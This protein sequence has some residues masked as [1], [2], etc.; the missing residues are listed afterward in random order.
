[1]KATTQISTTPSQKTACKIKKKERSL[2]VFT[3][4]SEVFSEKFAF[5]VEFSAF[6]VAASHFQVSA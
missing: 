5:Q 6:D 1:M 4:E 3:Y 2:H